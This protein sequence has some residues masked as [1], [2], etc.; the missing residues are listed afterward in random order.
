MGWLFLA[1]TIISEV[2]GTTMMKLSE[3]YT[4]LIPSILSVFFYISTLAFMTF[5]LKHL[6]IGITYALWSGIGIVLVTIIGFFLFNETISFQKSLFIVLI[7]VGAVGL[8]LST[9]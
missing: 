9:Q 6:G 5:T 3:G 4:K 7:L 1:L 2:S 8:K